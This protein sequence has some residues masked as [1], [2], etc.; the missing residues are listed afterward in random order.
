MIADPGSPATDPR[1]WSALFAFFAV[2]V[3]YVTA[4]LSV[5]NKQIDFLLYDHKQY[6]ELQKKRLEIRIEE[7]R[8]G[9]LP[10]V[11]EW[12]KKRL[13]LE[14]DMF[15]DRF[16]SLQFDGYVAWYDGYV[17]TSLYTFWLLARWREMYDPSPEWTLD[18]TTVPASLEIVSERWSL[19]PDPRS[20]ETHQ[21][22]K[23]VRLM[24]DLGTERN[25][26]ID[27]LLKQY[28]LSPIR[29]VLRKFLGAY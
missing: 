27:E 16:W 9:T 14:V 3:A 13:A 21:L 20:R 29:R 11:S 15:F 12:E 18:K 19:N 6:D 24:T 10:T 2:G 7:A 4:R 8:L 5:K 25:V 26:N 28:G 23:F 1:V 17:P 22:D